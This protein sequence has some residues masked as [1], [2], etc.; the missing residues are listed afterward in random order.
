LPSLRPFPNL[1]VMTQPLAQIFYE[2][3]LPGSQLVHRM[4][5]LGYRVQTVL[6]VGLFAEV[7]TR[8]KPMVVVVDLRVRN[9]NILEEVKAV[10]AQAETNHIPILGMAADQDPK[11]LAAAQAAGVALVA[12][13]ASIG[14]Q[15]PQLLEHVLR[16]E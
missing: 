6:E 13:V 4:Q 14:G 3:L 5:D 16:V 9:G 1:P 12:H 7:V 15:L 11:L 8:E 10:K 2:Q